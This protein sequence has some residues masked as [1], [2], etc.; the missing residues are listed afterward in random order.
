VHALNNALKDVGRI[1]WIS[2]LVEAGIPHLQHHTSLA[3]Y[4]SQVRKEFLKPTKPDMS[5]AFFIGENV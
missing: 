2:D 5:T 4:R 1:S 3:I